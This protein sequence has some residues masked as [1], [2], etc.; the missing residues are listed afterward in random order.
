MLQRDHLSAGVERG[1]VATQRITEQVIER[2]TAHAHRDALHV[3]AVVLH[4]SGR[5]TGGDHR[6][7]VA[8]KVDGGIRGVGRVGLDARHAIA[9]GVVEGVRAADGECHLDRI[10]VGLSHPPEIEYIGGY[11]LRP[12]YEDN[13]QS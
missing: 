11:V 1:A 6:F 2:R 13:L 7:R 12:Y 3:G 9:L 4:R 8:I 5:A 10:H